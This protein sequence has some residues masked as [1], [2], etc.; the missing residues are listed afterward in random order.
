MGI[1]ER[2][3]GIQNSFESKTK[4]LGR[5]K[6]GRILKM[7]RTPTREEYKKTCYIAAL[8]MIVVGA[9]GFAIMWIMT[10]LP[11]YF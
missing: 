3:D 6:Y 2:A 1:E 7:A 9:V 10:Y 8:G 5:G 11:D 4:N